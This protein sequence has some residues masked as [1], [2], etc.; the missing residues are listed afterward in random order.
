[1]SFQ[2]HT[3]LIVDETNSPNISVGQVAEQEA[4][5]F[6]SVNRMSEN[7]MTAKSQVPS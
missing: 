5:S 4:D 3:Y 6:E 1:M 7:C 2:P